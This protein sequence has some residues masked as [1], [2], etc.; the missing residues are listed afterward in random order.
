MDIA[1]RFQKAFWAAN[2][3]RDASYGSWMNPAMNTG[4]AAV[5]AAAAAAAG[6]TPVPSI[7]PG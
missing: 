6:N 2:F 4:L 5:A 3:G 1:G 7:M